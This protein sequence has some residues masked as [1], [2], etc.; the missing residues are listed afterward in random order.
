MQCE[1]E[2]L[3]KLG[4]YHLAVM[5]LQSFSVRNQERYIALTLIVEIINIIVK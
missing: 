4:R 1:G 5:Q 3:I 2:I